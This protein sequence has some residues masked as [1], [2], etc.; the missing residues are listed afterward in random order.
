MRL[1]PRAVQKVGSSLLLVLIVLEVFLVLIYL[2]GILLTGKAYPPFDMDGVKTIPSLLQA[3]QLF[4]IGFISLS[5]FIAGR[6]S[7]KRPSRLF[8]LTVALLFIYASVD[9]VFKIHLQ[10]HDLLDTA[11]KRVWMPVYLGIGLTTLLVFYRDFIALW[12]FHRRSTLFVALGMGIFVL[13]GFG[14]EVLKVILLQPL[15]SQITQHGDLIAVLVEKSRVAVEEFSEMLG[16]SITL[17]GIFLYVAKRLEP[18]LLS[19]AIKNC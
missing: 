6:H 12:H 17:Y 10:L 14:A 1:K 7:S 13:G 16:E 19:S 5:L 2:A 8:L 4:G 18:E 11:H 15:L 3:L 9:E